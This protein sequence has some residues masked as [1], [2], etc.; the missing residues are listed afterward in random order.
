MQW[1]EFIK[2]LKKHK[3]DYFYKNDV[4]N[5]LMG[6]IHALAVQLLAKGI[7][8]FLVAHRT[9]VGTKELNEKHIVVALSIDFYAM[10]KW[11]GMTII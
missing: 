2:V 1:R 3:A 10:D 6:L 9:K 4:P 5:K 7:I 8:E 11:N